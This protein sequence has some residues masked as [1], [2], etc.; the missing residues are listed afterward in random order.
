[1]IRRPPR[2]T[3]FP[4]TTLF[5]SLPPGASGDISLKDASERSNEY[6]AWSDT[7]GGSYLPTPIAYDGGLYVLNEVGILTRFDTKTGKQSYKSRLAR[8][9]S[10]GTFTSTR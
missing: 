8:D 7:K 5:R 10:S 2:S 6:I 9:G 3:L 4:Y 1:M